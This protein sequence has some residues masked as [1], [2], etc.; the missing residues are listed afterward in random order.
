MIRKD[1]R[2]VIGNLMVMRFRFVIPDPLLSSPP[3]LA[4]PA[5]AGI[6]SLR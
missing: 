4:I 1:V 5:Q 3:L 6:Q 2:D